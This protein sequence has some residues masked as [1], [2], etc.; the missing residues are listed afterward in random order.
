MQVIGNRPLAEEIWA[1]F[2]HFSILTTPTQ[3][4]LGSSCHAEEGGAGSLSDL[5]EVTTLSGLKKL[6]Y[7]NELRD[8]QYGEQP[9]D[10][11]I[12]PQG[13]PISLTSIHY[14][15]H[16]LLISLQGSQ[17]SPTSMIHRSPQ[18]LGES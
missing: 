9:H 15:P 6:S 8:D 18:R 3:D 11:L 13:S 17:I 16:D 10:S 2:A 4:I 7:V 12:S 1:Y 5:R 14:R